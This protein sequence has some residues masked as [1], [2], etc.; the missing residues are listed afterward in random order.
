MCHVSFACVTRLSAARH[1]PCL[2]NKLLDTSNADVYIYLNVYVYIYI[3]RGI[4][5]Q[6]T[7]IYSGI[8]THPMQTCIYTSMCNAHIS[9]E[10]YIHIHLTNTYIY[11]YIH[12]CIRIQY[13][14]IYASN[15][16]RFTIGK[17]KFMKMNAAT[18][19]PCL[20]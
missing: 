5:T 14:Y 11:I 15:T 9:I 3:Y 20:V 16:E 4:Y 13:I 19:A 10:V 18:H 12:I 17:G 1:A 2:A 6:C 7:H 8:Y